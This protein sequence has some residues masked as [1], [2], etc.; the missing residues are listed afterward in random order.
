MEVNPTSKAVKK[1]DEGSKLATDGI[2]LYYVKSFTDYTDYPN[3]KTVTSFVKKG[4]DASP[5][6]LTSTPELSAAAV[7]L[8]EIDPDNGDFYIGTTDY[9]TNGTIYRFDKTGK[10]I[11]KFETSGISPNH[12][13][14][15]K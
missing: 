14:F 13:A 6:D 15:V 8:F 1:F 3:T 2:N 5:F 10:F 12:A 11:T 7:Y 4:S 9:A